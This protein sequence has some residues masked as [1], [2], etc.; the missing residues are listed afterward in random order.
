[1]S[2]S[3]WLR[4]LLL[5]TVAFGALGDLHAAEHQPDGLPREQVTLRDG[6]RLTGWFD[7][8]L[9]ILWLDGPYRARLRLRPGDVIRR[10]PLAEAAPASM[11]VTAGPGASRQL[12]IRLREQQVAE[13]ERRHQETGESIRVLTLTL[14]GL[15]GL[16]AD[17]DRTLADRP[18][19]VADAAPMSHQQQLRRQIVEMRRRL[20][21]LDEQSKALDKRREQAVQLLA[22][23]RASPTGGAEPSAPPAAMVESRLQALEDEVRALRADNQDLRR[24][25]DLLRTPPATPATPSTP[26]PPPAPE[27]VSAADDGRVAR[28]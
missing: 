12:A 8:A 6:R 18:D 3:S 16:L 21:Q 25:L 17:L 28:R 1:M 9:A 26:A 14:G 23:A 27:A 7:P 15:E 13:L 4:P 5:G 24:Q 20:V 10:S 19:P 2:R 22:R 11:T